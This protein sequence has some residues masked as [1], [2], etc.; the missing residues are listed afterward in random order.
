MRHQHWLPIQLV[1]YVCAI[2]E[3]QEMNKPVIMKMKL[4]LNIRLNIEYQEM[5]QIVLLK[6][7]LM[8]NR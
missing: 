3:R 5:G 8:L 7:H 6:I 2:E 1:L 4:M